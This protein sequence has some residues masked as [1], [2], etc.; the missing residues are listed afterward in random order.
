MIM[1]QK[2]LF[3]NDM[4]CN[5]ERQFHLNSITGNRIS[6]L[7]IR[8]QKKCFSRARF[9]N[10][11]HLFTTY[12]KCIINVFTDPLL[13]TNIMSINLYRMRDC[14]T[15]YNILFY[16]NYNASGKLSFK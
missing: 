4:P 9:Q 10:L 1:K 13:L 6:Y 14:D 5:Y 3:L 12:K 15:C 11:R 2:Q 16:C 7:I 8:I